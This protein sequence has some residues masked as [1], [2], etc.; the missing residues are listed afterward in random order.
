MYLKNIKDN[1]AVYIID[2]KVY[3][4]YKKFFVNKKIILFN[5]LE[6]NKSFDT[7]LLIY[8][9]L[10]VFKTN[11]NT[12]IYAIGG[13]ITLD[14]A[15]FIAGTY[16][17]G[18]KLILVPSTLLAQVDASYGGKT[19]LNLKINNNLLKNQVGLFKNPE[20]IIIIF[21]LLKTLSKK[22]LLNGFAEL[23]KHSIIADKNLF[24]IIKLINFKTFKLSNTVD[25]KLIKKLIKTSILIKASIV[26]K[27]YYDTSSRKK[28]NLGHSFAHA[29]ETK[30]GLSH[31]FSVLLGIIL[32]SKISYKLKYLN[33]IDYEIILKLIYSLLSKDK[34]KI[35]NNFNKEE[36]FSFLKK[37]KKSYF[38]S[39][40]FVFIL[41][42]SKVFVKNI[43]F[44]DL[45]KIVYDLY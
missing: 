3:K 12:T 40:D 18:L 31:G 15:G 34:L 45:E 30:Y 26:K 11:K 28:L 9:K 14:I 16:L 6:T 23:I 39:I 44:K 29:F 42:I 10:A 1:N 43:D 32:A 24:N 41:K 36:V 35:I 21:D 22:E 7:V 33:S 17:R 25:F 19:A 13:G 5:S 2:K 4:L 37:D 27:D 20:K 8:K 38:T